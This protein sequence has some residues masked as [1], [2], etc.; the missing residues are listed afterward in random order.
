MDIFEKII[1]ITPAFDGRNSDPKKNY[2]VHGMDIRF[3]LKGSNGATQFVVFTPMYLSHVHDELF[4]KGH[5]FKP[6]GADIGY[7]SKHPQYA[8]HEAMD[9][10]YTDEGKCYY[11]GS[12]LA[13]DEFMPEFLSG[14]S[15]AVWKML[16]DRYNKI[17]GE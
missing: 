10:P 16:E 13:A 9:C 14:G 5:D 1:K 2:G 3:V 17:L 7:H 4:R 15:D 8:E 12:S 11:D 6:V